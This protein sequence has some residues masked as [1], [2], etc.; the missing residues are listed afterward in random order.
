MA[1]KKYNCGRRC[2]PQRR[3][4]S[5]IRSAF[6]DWSGTSL[7]IGWFCEG[8]FA[9]TVVSVQFRRLQSHSY[10]LRVCSLV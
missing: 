5:Y 7:I 4:V 2:I 1:A 6:T 8:R 9:V 3:S 10:C